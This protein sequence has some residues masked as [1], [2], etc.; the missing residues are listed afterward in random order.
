MASREW[1]DKNSGYTTLLLR[2]QHA[3]KV[4]AK[5]VTKIMV[6]NIT[7]TKI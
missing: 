4:V 7:E 3:S 5:I 6:S 2:A 1:W